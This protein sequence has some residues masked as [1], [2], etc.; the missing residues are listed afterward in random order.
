M[1]VDRHG[2]PPSARLALSIARLVAEPQRRRRVELRP[3][4]RRPCRSAARCR[5]AARRPARQAAGAGQIE[6]RPARRR[7]EASSSAPS[8]VAEALSVSRR[9]EPTETPAASTLPATCGMPKASSM[10]T[11]P[12]ALAATT[13]SAAMLPSGEADGDRLAAAVR[14]EADARLRRCRS[15]R[16]GQARQASRGSAPRRTTSRTAARRRPARWRR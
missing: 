4:S 5:G 6:V 11:S 1:P 12:S 9:T 7:F 8:T 15:P 10:R 3:G 13:V 2:P 16:R 14:L